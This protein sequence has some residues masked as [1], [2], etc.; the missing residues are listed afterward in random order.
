[1]PNIFISLHI[2][3]LHITNNLSENKYESTI[4]YY[5]IHPSGIE[6][7]NEIFEVNLR[8]IIA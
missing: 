3:T 4:S 2:T 7:M 6:V 8:A 5:D 1:M